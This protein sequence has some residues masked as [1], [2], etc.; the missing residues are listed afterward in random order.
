V[1]NSVCSFLCIF[2]EPL[3]KF[4]FWCI[5]ATVKEINTHIKSNIKYTYQISNLKHKN[6]WRVPQW[7]RHATLLK[8]RLQPLKKANLIFFS[9]WIQLVATSLIL[10]ILSLVISLRI[11][12][13]SW[14]CFSW[15]TRTLFSSFKSFPWFSI[16]EQNLSPRQIGFKGTV[17]VIS[18]GPPCK[19]GNVEFSTVALKPLFDQ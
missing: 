18:S 7:T 12:L 16:S 9:I 13:F 1:R 17:S 8:C 5:W 3:F 14:T 15:F 6:L 11:R 2:L 4:Y 10:P 19:Y